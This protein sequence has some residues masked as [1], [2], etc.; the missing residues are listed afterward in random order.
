MIQVAEEETIPRI[1]ISLPKGLYECF[2]RVQSLRGGSDSDV[3]R[4][5]IEFYLM[6]NGL[7]PDLLSEGNKGN[8]DARP[9]K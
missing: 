8:K 1:Q 7:L 2:K 6:H 5:M 9:A 4:S 3:G